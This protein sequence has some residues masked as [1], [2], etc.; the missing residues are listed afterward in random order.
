MTS[1]LPLESSL[2]AN[3]PLSWF[4]RESCPVS[5]QANLLTRSFYETYLDLTTVSTSTVEKGHATSNV[6]GNM[7]V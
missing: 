1:H 6:H 7:V 3:M 4:Y 2:V 5:E